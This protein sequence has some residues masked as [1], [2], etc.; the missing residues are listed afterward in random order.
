MSFAQ[1]LKEETALAEHFFEPYSLLMSVYSREKAQFLRE[2]VESVFKQSV[3]PGEFVL[4]ID[5]PVGKELLSEI[6]NLRQRFGILVP[7]T[8]V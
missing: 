4:V 3:L 1:K 5:G 8:A 6:E 7:S 2:S